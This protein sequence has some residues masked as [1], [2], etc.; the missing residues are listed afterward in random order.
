M[1][2]FILG[3]GA[4]KSGTTWLFKQLIKSPRYAGGF[5]KEYHLFDALHVGGRKEWV[6]G[7]RNRVSNY[8]SKEGEDFVERHV[9]LMMNFYE[10]PTAYYDYFDSI[11]K[12]DND[13]SLDITPSYSALDAE[14][15]REIRRQFLSRDIVVKVVFLMREP[16]TRL[17]SAIK[18]NLRRKKALKSAGNQEV[19]AKMKSLIGSEFNISRSDYATTC[20]NIDNAFP[21]S[22]IFYGFHETLFSQSEV[23]RLGEFL[24]LPADL[25]DISQVV[26]RTVKRFN[27][28][29]A[30]VAALKKCV[31]DRYDYVSGR[32]GFDLSIWDNALQELVDHDAP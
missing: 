30:D 14:V 15:L 12:A 4:Q 7:A 9:G 31:Q 5:C 28:P 8:P 24:N 25:F 19:A 1:R 32:F 16:V 17:E 2:T 6:D 23:E 13:F 3:V 21:E 26:N 10:D 29:A 20:G 18:M 11:I 27:Y 22:E